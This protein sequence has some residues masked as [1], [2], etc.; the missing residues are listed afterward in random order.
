MRDE[1]RESPDISKSSP[2]G[3]AIRSY[4]SESLVGPDMKEE[5][6]FDMVKEPIFESIIRTMV[7]GNAVNL[8]KKA[9]IKIKDS[10]V[11]IGVCDDRGILGE[12]EV[13]I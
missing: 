4:I 10:C 2:G 13:F 1:G 8:K 12:G 6:F 11:L 9:R 7:L 5:H 3:S